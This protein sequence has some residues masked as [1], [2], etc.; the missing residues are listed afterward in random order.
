MTR[1]IYDGIKVLDMSQGAT[2]PLPM[3]WLGDHGATVI[4]IETHLR[5]DSA[6]MGGPFY[7]FV[8]GADRGGWEMWLNSSKYSFTVN[9][10]KP[11]GRDLIRQLVTKWKPNILAESYRPGIMAKW[12]LGYEDIRKLK[13]DII[14]YSSCIEGQ[15]G[16]HCMRLGYGL[17]T[18]NLSGVS[19]LTG[20]PDRPPAGMPLAYGDFPSAGTGAIALAAALIRQRK[21][22]KGVYLDQSQYEANLYVLAG[23]ILEYTVNGR[24]MG[25]NGNRMSGAAPHGVYPCEGTERWVAIAVFTD[26]EWHN[27]CRVIGDPDW[28]RDS[29][30][31]TLGARKQ[32]ED[33]LDRLVGG[34]TKTRKAEDVE[35]MMQAKGVAANV[36][37]DNRDI[38]EDPQIRYRGHFKELDH[39]VVGKVRSELPPFRFSKSTER[40]FRAPLLGE[41]NHLV[42]SEF[43]G[44]SDDQISDLY[45]EGVITTDADLP[46]PKQK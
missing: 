15:Y 11:E 17:V 30:F 16:P 18:T 5:L 41:H 20:W 38:Y 27:F 23:P 43:L 26:E 12:G 2:I 32:N 13:P 21:T 14:Y 40:H 1:H 6:R 19:H 31:N 28:T 3:K 39:P 10:S 29:R 34:W 24:V 22:G 37:E 44:L 36:V 9:L 45:A 35:A 4:K 46:Q 8:P 25:R 42:L 33:E 7:Q